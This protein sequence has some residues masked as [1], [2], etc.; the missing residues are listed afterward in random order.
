M[1][2]LPWGLGPEEAALGHPCPKLLS[3]GSPLHPGVLD[4]TM[5][6]VLYPPSLCSTL[7]FD[8]ASF[9]KEL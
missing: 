3:E 2:C 6:N 9:F 4:R 7:M 8:M 1:G 5:G